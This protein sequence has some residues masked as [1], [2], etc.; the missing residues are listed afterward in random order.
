MKGA[1]P[2][3]ITV[4]LVS[5]TLLQATHAQDPPMKWKEINR[6]Q[7]AMS[8][9]AADPDA[10]AVLLADFGES[11]LNGEFDLVY[12]RHARIKILTKAGYEHGSFTITYHNKDERVRNIDG[13]TYTLAQDSSISST[14]MDGSAIFDENVDGTYRR[15]RF[16]LPALRPGCII[17]VRYRITSSSL[18]RL[19]DWRFQRGIPVLWSEY[20]VMIPRSIVYAGV[21]MGFEPFHINEKHEVMQRFDGAAVSFLRANNVTCN[22]YRWVVRNAPALRSEPYI[23]TIKDYETRIELQLAAYADPNGGVQRVLKD[24]S[25]VRDELLESRFFGEKIEG[26]K[27]IRKLAEETT[28]GLTAPMD[29]MKAIYNYVR[30]AIVWSE[31]N[32]YSSD[33][34]V[35]EILESKNGSSSE[36]SFVLLSMLKSIGIDARPVI[37]STRSNGVLQDVYPILDQFDYVLAQVRIEGKTHYLDATNPVRPYDLL[38]VNVLNVKGLVIADGP[39]EWVTVSSLKRFEHVTSTD[40]VLTAEGS[41]R[42]RVESSEVDYSGMLN[43]EAVKSKD[44]LEMLKA[45][46]SA[47]ASGVT[48]DSAAIEAADSVDVP[49]LAHAMIHGESYAQI[50]G[51]LIYVNPHVINRIS[52]NPLKSE[53]R[54][55]PVDM[56]YATTS[57]TTVRMKLPEGFTVHEPLSSRSIGI[58]GKGA[59]YSRTF[60]VKDDHVLLTYRF[61]INSTLFPPTS[62]K[63]L[64]NFYSQVVSMQSEQ[65]VLQ[66]VLPAAVK[67]N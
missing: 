15:K 52:N 30:S 44:E 25:E 65:V 29:K 19:R 41:I 64:R 53:R 24:W 67:K 63:E 50:S 3:L 38:P 18:F 9:Y 60:E 11:S 6:A 14:A 5:G 7:L 40:I 58:K 20:R 59:T 39:L 28:A 8:S 61:E 32:R 21:T 17:D 43:R 12:D 22:Q 31:K 27:T 26:T 13:I 46:L 55:Y 54:N 42:G 16:T 37:L 35:D 4:A 51:D 48:L 1:T 47:E 10:E 57:V 56:G 62:Y 34:D 2:L 33:R 23:T 66:R 49:L 45:A 36:I